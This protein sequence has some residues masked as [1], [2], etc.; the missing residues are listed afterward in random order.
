VRN[1]A[2]RPSWASERSS[3]SSSQLSNHR[4]MAS[5]PLDS[6]NYGPRPVS[7][8]SSRSTEST[9]RFC[10][11]PGSSA[12]SGS[13]YPTADPQWTTPTNKKPPGI[14]SKAS[15]SSLKSASGGGSQK[16]TI[17]KEPARSLS[18]FAIADES[19]PEPDPEP[20]D[21]LS[22]FSL[23]AADTSFDPDVSDDFGT[24]SLRAS[25]ASTNS[26]RSA[27]VNSHRSGRNHRP[28]SSVGQAISTSG[29]RAGGLRE[30]EY[31]TS[32]TVRSN[33]VASNGGNTMEPLR[34][35]GARR[36]GDLMHV[37]N[38]LG[39]SRGATWSRA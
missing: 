11:R 29:R 7:V 10:P 39:K 15:N 26:L 33:S 32:R 5:S 34:S 19:E 9:G 27:S 21:L 3:D 12:S 28:S 22:Q 17:S 25:T 24:V 31:P 4:R 16:K 6:S 37:T 36:N 38:S 23:D 1:L 8:A 20:T 13:S 2:R 18:S 14:V 30:F 35:P